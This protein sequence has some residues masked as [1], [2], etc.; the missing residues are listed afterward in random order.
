MKS[1]PLRAL[2]LPLLVPFWMPSGCPINAPIEEPIPAPVV[3]LLELP[4]ELLADVPHPVAQ[5]NTLGDAAILI[6]AYRT[7]LESVNHER[8]ESREI[9]R[10]QLELI[11]G[12]RET[13]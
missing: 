4:E 11:A 3:V 7:T 10:C 2:T 8:L 12:L 5:G 9:R 6:E 1:V 13:C